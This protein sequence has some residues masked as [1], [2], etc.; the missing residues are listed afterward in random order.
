MKPTKTLITLG[1]AAIILVSLCITPAAAADNATIN[2][3]NSSAD[4]AEKEYTDWYATTIESPYYQAYQAAQNNT[5]QPT[6]SRQQVAALLLDE[7]K[8]EEQRHNEEYQLM[9]LTDKLQRFLDAEKEHQNGIW[10]IKYEYSVL[11]NI[12]SFF[13]GQQDIY[14][15]Y[16]EGCLAEMQYHVNMQNWLGVKSRHLLHLEGY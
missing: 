2:A 4:A 13:G 5:L 16:Y 3:T 10:Y 9:G 12:W 8:S 7:T 15:D 14:T 1:I 6:V 11:D